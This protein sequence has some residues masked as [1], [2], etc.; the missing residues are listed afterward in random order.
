MIL[1]LAVT[2]GHNE[3]PLTWY[4]NTSEV[5]RRRWESNPCT[6]LCRPLPEPLGHVAVSGHDH[7]TRQ[8]RSRYRVNS[9]WELYSSTNT[10]REIRVTMW[11]DRRG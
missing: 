5:E 7:A 11:I 3:K 1:R 6:G 10:Q 8:D 2:A 9:V 4:N